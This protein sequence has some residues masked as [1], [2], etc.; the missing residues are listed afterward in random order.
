[1]KT[2]II[3]SSKKVDEVLKKYEGH[4]LDWDFDED[5]NVRYM[6]DINPKDLR[7]PSALSYQDSVC[8]GRHLM[9]TDTSGQGRR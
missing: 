2:Y 6:V 7:T 1:M 9:T 4:I 5:G 3:K 8:Q